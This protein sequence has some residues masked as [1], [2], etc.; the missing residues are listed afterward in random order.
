[1]IYLKDKKILFLKPIKVAG[2]SFE[3]ALSKFA[4]TSDIITPLEHIEDAELRRKLRYRDAQNYKMKL[5]DF[6]PRDFAKSLYNRE[7]PRKFFNHIFH[8]EYF[9]ILFCYSI[10]H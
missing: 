6:T 8:I 5:R 2:T 1:M 10:F 9:L 4:S 7:I 3:I